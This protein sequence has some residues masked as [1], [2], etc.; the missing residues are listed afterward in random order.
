MRYYDFWYFGDNCLPSQFLRI[1]LFQRVQQL[2]GRFWPTYDTNVA[3]DRQYLRHPNTK[4][5]LMVSDED[6]DHDST[7]QSRR[8]AE[9]DS[10]C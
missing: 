1:D 5:L 2:F 8:T 10:S 6:V 3:R 9:S 4:K 7:F